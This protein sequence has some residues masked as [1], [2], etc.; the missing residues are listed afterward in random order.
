MESSALFALLRVDTRLEITFGSL[1]FL[2]R[3]IDRNGLVNI[4]EIT[5][6][7]LFL[8]EQKKAVSECHHIV[9]SLHPGHDWG[10]SDHYLQ[11]LLHSHSP[12]MPALHLTP[13]SG[14]A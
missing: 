12:V 7:C 10:Q 8:R 2:Y 3:D 11:I 1:K 6:L 9:L 14:T 5:E 4:L 13:M